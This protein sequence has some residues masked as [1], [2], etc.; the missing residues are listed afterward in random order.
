[1]LPMIIYFHILP[2]YI[3]NNTIRLT[4]KKKYHRT[5][6]FK[7]GYQKLTHEVQFLAITKAV[8]VDLGYRD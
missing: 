3:H 4:D 5:N 6:F 7:Q 1:M 2:L 8:V